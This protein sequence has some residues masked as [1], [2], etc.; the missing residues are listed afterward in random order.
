MASRG[1]AAERMAAMEAASRFGRIGLAQGLSALHVAVLPQAAPLVGVVLVQWERLLRDGAVP[2]FL[3]SM[4]APVVAKQGSVAT[5][6]QR[7]ACA[8]SLEAVLEMVKRT[9]GRAVNADAPLMESGVDS[10]GAI[11]LRN[12]LQS[13]AGGSATLPSTLIFDHPT[14]RALS[15]Y[16]TAAAPVRVQVQQAAVT[17]SLIHI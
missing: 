4:A 2:A 14:A 17:L 13:A 16:F 5:V 15:A 11:E 12:Q 7:A 8:V 9:A 1:A 10:L 3:C 6:E